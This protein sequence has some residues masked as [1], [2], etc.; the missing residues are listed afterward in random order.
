MHD[1]QHLRQEVYLPQ[2]IEQSIAKKQIHIMAF[3]Q[4]DHS[5]SIQTT[6]RHRQKWQIIYAPWQQTRSMSMCRNIT[7]LNKHTVEKDGINT[8]AQQIRPKQ[9]IE[10]FLNIV[11]SAK[12]GMYAVKP[13][14][15]RL[16]FCRQLGVFAGNANRR[17]RTYRSEC[18]EEFPVRQLHTI[19]QHHFVTESELRICVIMLTL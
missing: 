4:K 8:N 9:Q 5:P 2:T 15:R 6:H 13:F 19:H 11:M 18:G 12:C 3:W 10:L 7:I 14:H 16:W 1:L 17:L